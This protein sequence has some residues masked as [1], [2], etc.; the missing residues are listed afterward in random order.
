MNKYN[1][2]LI[3]DYINGNDI[4]EYTLE[5]LEND[6]KF[7]NRVMFLTRDKNIYKLCSKEIKEN[8]E[9][10]KQTIIIFNNDIEFISE[11][12]DE[13][14]KISKDLVSFTELILLMCKY[15]KNN[16][17]YFKKYSKYRELIYLDFKTQIEIV[18]EEYKGT[19]TYNELGMGFIFIID[20]FNS[21]KTILDYFALKFILELLTEYEINLE[22]LIH[23]DFDTYQELEEYGVNK[24]IFALLD[25]YDSCLSGYVSTNREILNPILKRLKEIKK[26]W[27]LYS[28]KKLKKQYELMFER[29]FDY[30]QNVKNSTFEEI[31][32]IYSLGEELGISEQ[33]KKYDIF[34]DDNLY[35]QIISTM[36]IRIQTTRFNMYDIKYITDVKNIMIETLELKVNNKHSENNLKQKVLKKVL[37]KTNKEDN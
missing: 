14:I 18:K 7:M 33:L 19:R 31:E 12:I 1:I 9:F 17:E 20:F 37:I 4:E 25:K 28:E 26:E 13:Y 35:D 15:T 3:N 6:P 27:H 2:K 32:L 30:L 5:E 8:P 23:K 11:I 21:S 22:D 36:D 16:E 34:I 24:Y 10:V 29:V